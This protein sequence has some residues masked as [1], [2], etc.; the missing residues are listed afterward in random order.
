MAIL[1][2][3]S[4]VHPVHSANITEYAKSRRKSLRLD[5]NERRRFG[6]LDLTVP[7]LNLIINFPVP[8][9]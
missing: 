7:S 2:I 9:I 3:F 5:G 1:H 6:T 4:T 8:L